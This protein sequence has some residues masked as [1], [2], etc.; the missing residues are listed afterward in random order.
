MIVAGIWEP[1]A[2]PVALTS[3]DS[4]PYAL[5]YHASGK[6]GY[7]IN[8]EV[9]VEKIANEINMDKRLNMTHSGVMKR[10]THGVIG[11]RE[12]K[13]AYPCNQ[14]QVV[15]G[16]TKPAGGLGNDRTNFD[17]TTK[18]V[19]IRGISKRLRISVQSIKRGID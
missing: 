17:T 9:S 16:R 3:M 15:M 2:V 6:G 4:T 18:V 13:S 7:F 11:N 8:K 1:G 14:C 5:E 12:V 19:S 10:I